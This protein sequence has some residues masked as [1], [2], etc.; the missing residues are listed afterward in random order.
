MDSR[1]KPDTHSNS[2]IVYISTVTVYRDDHGESDKDLLKV[3]T[4]LFYL[5]SS[6]VCGYS[7]TVRFACVSTSIPLNVSACVFVNLN[8]VILCIIYKTVQI[9]WI[10]VVYHTLGGT[11]DCSCQLSLRYCFA[12]VWFVL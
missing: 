5:V 1:I 11:A 12:N 7:C 4:G 10:K 6:W 8:E 9:V 3:A 2:I